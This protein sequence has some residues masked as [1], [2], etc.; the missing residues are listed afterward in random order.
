MDENARSVLRIGYGIFSDFDSQFQTYQ[1]L[2][3]TAYPFTQLELLQ[4]SARTV[5]AG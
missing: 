2:G 5:A 3:A 4:T 1:A